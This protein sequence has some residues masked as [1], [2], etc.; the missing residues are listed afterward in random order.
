MSYA[1]WGDAPKTYEQTIEAFEVSRLILIS[2]MFTS[3][4]APSGGTER[5]NQWHKKL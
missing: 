2:T 5:L 4:Y 3:T 1:A